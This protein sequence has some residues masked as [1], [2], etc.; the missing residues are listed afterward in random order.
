MKF[1]NKINRQYFWTLSI[2][3]MVVSLVGYFVLRMIL[4][5]EIK[6]DILEK[7]YAIV[8]EIKSDGNLPNIYPIIE[9]KKVT[10]NKIEAKSYK[11]IYISDESENELEPY[12]EYT[13][14]VKINNQYYLIKLRHSLLENDA[15]IVAIALP[16]LLLLILT[17]T[18]L[19]ILTKKWN[20]T[21]WKDFE[22]NLQTIESFSFKNIQDLS[23][24][25]THIEEFDR[26]NKTI[27]NLTDKLS[28]DYTILKQF[29]ENASHELQ[30]P[31]SI[32]LLNLEE[33]LQ[34]DLPEQAFK[35]VVASI[36]AVK[37]LSSL[38]QS[39][40]LLTKIENNQFNDRNELIINKIVENKM[41]E[42]TPLLEKQQLKIEL[43]TSESLVLKLNEKL[44]GILINNLFSNAV[45]HNIPNGTIEITIT[46]NELKIC[47]TG[48]ENT[49]TNDTVFNRFTKENSQSY[50][51]GL[52]IVKQICDN[53]H[54]K[55]YYTKENE[56][57][58]FTINKN[59]IYFKKGY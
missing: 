51:L 21:L 43:N 24:K 1:L 26:L 17:F 31:L 37:R 3:L 34:Q 8:K 46:E 10:K 42:F 47:N 50:G 6:E 48:K 35:Q 12:L 39:L 57:H 55:I 20:K 45:K 2:S 33:L 44:A 30:T 9:T 52:A 5:D 4:K 13:N 18:I 7:E 49:L 54:L 58:C 32:I 36:N 11:E 38:N 53:H 15:L 56:K 16:L 27:I 23:L 25:Q 41:Q 14:T 19:F 40:L 29:T 22:K 59:F 28:K